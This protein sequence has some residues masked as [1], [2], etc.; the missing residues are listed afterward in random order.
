MCKYCL[1]SKSN[2]IHWFLL[3]PSQEELDKIKDDIL[4]KINCI[5]EEDWDFPPQRQPTEV[6]F[7]VGIAPPRD[8]SRVLSPTRKKLASIYR[9]I[10]SESTLI[11]VYEVERTSFGSHYLQ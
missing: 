11:A 2:I 5:E 6:E 3:L 7:F 9:K 4:T 8:Y 1:L 10:E